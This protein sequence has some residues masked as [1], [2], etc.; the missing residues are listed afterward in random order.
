MKTMKPI[1]IIILLL[2]NIKCSA[3][4]YAAPVCSDPPMVREDFYG[5]LIALR[6]KVGDSASNEIE[7]LDYCDGKDHKSAYITY[8]PHV[9]LSNYA[10]RYLFSCSKKP[11]SK[12]WNC[13]KPT[14]LK[15]ITHQ[16][17]S[18]S[19]WGSIS[20]Q[21]AIE[22]IEFT[23]A[24]TSSS[25]DSIGENGIFPE[26]NNIDKYTKALAISKTDSQFREEYRVTV[27]G[28][29]LGNTMVL[30]RVQC[31]L[32]SCDLEIRELRLVMH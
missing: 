27:R 6:D 15:S 19:F 26:D 11:S 17:Y 4:S 12:L 24:I 25:F 9:R 18:V 1:F 32:A 3:L 5:L 20:P 10:E 8:A 22:V 31:G 16:G 14:V 13:N 23:E 28:G 7:K 2:V 21:E 29:M 30:R